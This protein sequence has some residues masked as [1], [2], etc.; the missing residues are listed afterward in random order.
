MFLSKV[1]RLISKIADQGKDI[2]KRI[3]SILR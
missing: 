3:N 1:A 2:T